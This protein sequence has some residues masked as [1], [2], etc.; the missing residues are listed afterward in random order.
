MAHPRL[1]LCACLLAVALA[2][3][4]DACSRWRK[5]AANPCVTCPHALV[6]PFCRGWDAHRVGQL[7]SDNP[8]PSIP[9][10]PTSSWTRWN[11]GWESGQRNSQTGKPEVLFT[12]DE[13]WPVINK[14]AAQIEDLQQWRRQAADRLDKLDPPAGKDKLPGQ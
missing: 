6:C 7:E 1:I 9:D 14:H 8:F 5:P 13:H 11:G 12:A 10:D 4:A 3:G 2:L